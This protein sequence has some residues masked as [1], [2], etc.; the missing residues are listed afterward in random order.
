MAGSPTAGLDPLSADFD[1]LQ[2]SR[3]KFLWVGFPVLGQ[4]ITTENCGWNLPL[5]LKMNLKLPVQERLVLR[6]TAAAATQW[7]MGVVLRVLASVGA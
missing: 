6:A 3:L 2:H 7:N 5:D 1:L 4:N